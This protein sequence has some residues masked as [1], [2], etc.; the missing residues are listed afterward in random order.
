MRV[1][2]TEAKNRVGCNL[3]QAKREPV[4][5]DFN[6]TYNEWIAS[7]NELVER[8]GVLGEEFRPW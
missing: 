6:H 4:H 7:R 3:G 1:T 2:E 8:M 5:R